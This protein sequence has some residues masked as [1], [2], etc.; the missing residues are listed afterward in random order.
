VATGPLASPG[1]E[2]LAPIGELIVAAG[3]DEGELVSLVGD[4]VALVVRGGGSRVSARIIDSA[5][6]LQVIARTGIG[7]DEVDVEAATRRGIPVVVVPDA[8]ASAV[9]EGALALMLAL[10]KRL[11]LLDRL[12]RDERWAER[13]RV[14]IRDVEGSTLGI[15][16]LG[17]IGRR[18]AAKA[19]ALGM[20]VVGVDPY[21]EAVNVELVDLPVLFERSH[22][23]SLH[24]PLTDETR[25]MVD[26]P[27]LARL[28]EGAILVNLARGALIRS[29][30][31]VLTAL[32]AGRLG[33]V[34]LDVFAEEPPD[35]SHPLFREERVLVSPHA[36]GM[37]RGAKAAI[38]RAAAEGVIA[39]LTGDRPAAV[40][41]PE[42]YGKR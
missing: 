11:T 17:R 23:V 2:L 42:I 38:A 30:D 12:V 3:R 25:G 5:P 36:L 22:F 24:V 9:A 32:E 33:G 37:S 15:V 7:V 39:V 34:G 20:D 41:N 19:K 29:L 40:A 16:G 4:A 13:D 10:A 35:L 31:D 1:P 14:D 26:A 21:A 6:E 28:P 27:L 8:G 18:L